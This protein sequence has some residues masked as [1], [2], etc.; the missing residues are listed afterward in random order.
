MDPCTRG[1]LSGDREGSTG[2]S[3]IPRSTLQSHTPMILTLMTSIAAIW[4][5]TNP[6]VVAKSVGLIAAKRMP[7]VARNETTAI[8]RTELARSDRL[9]IERQKCRGSRTRYTVPWPLKTSMT[10][11]SVCSGARGR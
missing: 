11:M 9:G 6:S 3:R 1:L 4:S 5:T 10:K 7:R 8:S 2:S